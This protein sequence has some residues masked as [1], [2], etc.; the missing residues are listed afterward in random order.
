MIYAYTYQPGPMFKTEFGEWKRITVLSLNT[1]KTLGVELTELATPEDAIAL[2]GKGDV[3]MVNFSLFGLPLHPVE[4]AHKKLG[5]YVR[6]IFKSAAAM[7]AAWG[8]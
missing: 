4:V 2:I 8:S 7:Q 3:Q 5:Q 6:K 1:V